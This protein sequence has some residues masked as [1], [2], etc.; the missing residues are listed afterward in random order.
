MAIKMRKLTN[1]STY[2]RTINFK[3]SAIRS[4]LSLCWI[5]APAMAV[6][7]VKKHVFRPADY[8]TN[9]EEKRILDT[10]STFQIEIHGKT[11]QGWKWGKGP[12]ILFVHGWNGRGIQFHRFF[13]RVTKA[14]F[15]VVT[16]DAPAH[17]DSSGHT[18]SYFEWT[19]TIRAM[20]K[21]QHFEIVGMVGHSLGGSAVINALSKE[22]LSMPTAL[23]APV[24]K[25]KEVL[26]S[27]FNLYGIPEAVYR[28][29]IVEYERRFGYTM[30]NDN[31][32][33]LLPTLDNDLLVVH[34]RQDQAIPFQ[35][36]KDMARMWPNIHIS[37]T[38]GLGHRRILTDHDVVASVVEYLID[39]IKSS[40][41]Q[42]LKYEQPSNSNQTLEKLAG[43]PY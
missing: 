23:I 30:H 21:S 26:Y 40:E 16:F 24:F 41:R 25:L 27:T 33:R 17:G 1:K 43:V 10:G 36:S 3:H 14:G 8:Q 13:E 7:F 15:S 31:P 4:F 11:I 38:E 29:A 9:P 6:R 35:D 19:D 2:V 5:L 12:S 28:R 39:K 20:L 37:E 32:H 22:Q 34:D 42:M 18:S